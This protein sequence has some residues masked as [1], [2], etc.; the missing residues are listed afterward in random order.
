MSKMGL[1]KDMILEILADEKEHAAK[2][3]VARAIEQGYIE[4]EKDTSV[5]NALHYLKID[6]VIGNPTKGSYVSMES[7][8]EETE[9]KSNQKEDDFELSVECICKAI[10][11][12]KDFNWWECSDEEW[13]LAKLRVTEL[14]KL[15]KKI[16]NIVK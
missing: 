3:F 9:E 11:S 5:R 12:L 16:Q 10:D 2:E 8:G 6:G 1:I 15:A 13:K 4:S 14:K 7:Y